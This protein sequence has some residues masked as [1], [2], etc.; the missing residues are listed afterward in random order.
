[1]NGAFFYLKATNGQVVA[2]NSICGRNS[3]T[4]KIVLFFTAKLNAETCLNYNFFKV[5]TTYFT[6]NSSV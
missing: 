1:M 5:I 3:K 2:G 4:V 6:E